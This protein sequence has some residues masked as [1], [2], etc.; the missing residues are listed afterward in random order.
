MSL[1][2]VLFDVDGTLADTEALGHRPAYNRA[3]RKLGLQMRWGPKL[4][5]RLLRLP[6]GRERLK[7]YVLH[8]R[9]DLG[10]EQAEVDADIDAWV[11]KVHELKSKYFRRR[12]RQG[13][14]PLRPGVA[15]V[16]REARRE[17][18]RLAIVTNASLKTLKPVLKYCMGP[19]LAAEIDVIA[20]GEEV[21]CKK[22]APDLY[23]LAMRRLGVDAG[24]CV[25]LEDSEMG[26]ESAAAAGVAAVVTVNS[27]TIEQDFCEAALVMSSLGEPG[28]PARVLR[29]KLPGVPWVTIDALRKVLE[30]GKPQQAQ[31]A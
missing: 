3:F 2:A 23:R 1:Q 12:M 10:A 27:D 14:V 18:L 5:R 31:A 8:Y 9:P 16:M 13:K 17:G 6:G 22:P 20:S 19:E 29:G 21:V 11:A 30:R 24:D 15:R 28:A 25:A 7:H 4:Y 26:L